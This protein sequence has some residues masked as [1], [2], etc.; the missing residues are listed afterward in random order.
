MTRQ[1]SEIKSCVNA[2]L[3]TGNVTSLTVNDIPC[4]TYT[5]GTPCAVALMRT[6]DDHTATVLQYTMAMNTPLECY[7]AIV[8]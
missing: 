8:G 2:H 5:I 3:T 7:P 4:L 6:C 1:Q